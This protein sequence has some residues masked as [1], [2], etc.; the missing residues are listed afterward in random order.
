HSGASPVVGLFRFDQ[1]RMHRVRIR[2]DGALRIDVGGVSNF[3]RGLEC[4]DVD[5]DGRRELILLGVYNA[6]RERPQWHKT[7]YEWQ[8]DALV[9]VDKRRGRLTR[10]GYSDPDVFRFYHLTCGDFDPPDPF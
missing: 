5:G 10:Q 6:L 1:G 7:I 9:L 4:K 2:G 3:G 8:G